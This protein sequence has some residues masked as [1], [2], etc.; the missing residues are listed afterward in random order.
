[1]LTSRVQFHA[2]SPSELSAQVLIE[3]SLTQFLFV[4]QLTFGLQVLLEADFFAEFILL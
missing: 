4:H 1:M 2:F 3:G